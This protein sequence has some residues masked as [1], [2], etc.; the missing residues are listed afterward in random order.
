MGAL[1]LNMECLQQRST[2]RSGPLLF[3]LISDEFYVDDLLSGHNNL[4][5][6]QEIYSLYNHLKLADF[7]LRKSIS[8]HSE[9]LSLIPNNEESMTS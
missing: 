9:V 4:K 6:F 1:Q 5:T 7:V 2:I 3:K 8:N